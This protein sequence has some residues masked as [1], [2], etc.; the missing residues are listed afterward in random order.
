V[1]S[2]EFYNYMHAIAISNHCKMNTIG[3]DF[4]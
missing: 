4:K 2:K 1:N 3:N